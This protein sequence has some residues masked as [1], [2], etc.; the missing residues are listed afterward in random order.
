[1]FICELLIFFTGP[2]RL[3]LLGPQLMAADTRFKY[4]IFQTAESLLI[5]YLPDTCLHK[6]ENA[7]IIIIIVNYI[8]HT[9]NS[10]G[11][12]ILPK[13]SVIVA[14]KRDIVLSEDSSGVPVKALGIS[15]HN[16]YILISVAAL[17]LVPDHLSHNSHLILAAYH[18]K[19]FKRFILLA[20]IFTYRISEGI[21]SEMLQRTGG[22][23]RTARSICTARSVCITRSS[24]IFKNYFRLIANS[25]LYVLKSI[26]TLTEQVMLLH[27][28]AAVHYSLIHAKRE[29]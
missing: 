5:F 20:C 4:V 1:M 9:N 16:D 17:Y 21:F 12:W 3:Y 27:I 22:G 8:E 11:I 25:L 15:C 19:D 29:P 23:V 18:R 10:L 28:K 6:S 24:S 26:H 13:T 14:E 7:V 2:V